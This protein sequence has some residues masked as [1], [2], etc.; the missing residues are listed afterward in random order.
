M[1]S[2]TCDA[3]EEVQSSRVGRHGEFGVGDDGG[4]IQIAGR[5][6]KT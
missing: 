1:V 3:I 6:W 4:S 2:V 5:D